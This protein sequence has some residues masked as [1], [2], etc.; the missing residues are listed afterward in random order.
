[1]SRFDDA[2]LAALM[3]DLLRILR[4]R[5]LDLLPF[6]KVR[7]ELRLRHVVDRG[8]QEV[9]LAN[10]VGS[11]GRA[12]EFNRA[13]L[14]R[15]DAQRDRWR[16][17]RELAE[18]LRGFDPVELYKVGEAYFVVDGH[19]RV[20]VARSLEA[21]TIEARVR[22]F[23][24]PVP[25]GPDDSIES[26]VLRSG[27][28]DFLAATGLVPEDEDEFRVTVPDGYA[29]LL[30]HVSVHRYYRGLETARDVPWEEAVASWRDAVYRPMIRAI[31]DS[32]IMGAFPGRTETD[33]YLFTMNHLHDLRER[34]GPEVTPEAAVSSLPWARPAESRLERLR[35]WWR[36]AHRASG[37]SED[38]GG[39]SG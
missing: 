30:E 20:S 29:R 21:P 24:T 1:M 27:L 34:Y 23:V 32:R 9:P 13:F 18:G 39:A 15:R 16:D 19:H 17:V 22:E 3:G 25:L 37:G 12:K 8:I 6:E 14:P 2:R 35:A 33:L 36:R 7:E 10:I 11:L 5:P 4:R 26:V 28:A 38:E 31:R